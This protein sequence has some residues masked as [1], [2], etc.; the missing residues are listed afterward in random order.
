MA[1]KHVWTINAA[2]N[3]RVG[4]MFFRKSSLV[5]AQGELLPLKLLEKTPKIQQT[6]GLP[7]WTLLSWVSWTD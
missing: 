7:R 5:S 3:T 6:L 1:A 4:L 2:T